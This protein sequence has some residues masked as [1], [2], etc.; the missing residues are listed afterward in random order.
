MNINSNTNPTI[1][2]IFQFMLRFTP[3]RFTVPER[4]EFIILEIT[5]PSLSKAKT[6]NKPQKKL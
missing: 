3:F 4:V 5:E 2:A 1:S 6:G